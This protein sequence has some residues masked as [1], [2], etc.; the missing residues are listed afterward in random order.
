[1]LIYN[2]KKNQVLLLL[3]LL[4]LAI[5]TETIGN[6]I[7]VPSLFLE[8]EYRNKVDFWSYFIMGFSLGV[9]TMSYHIISY[10]LDIPKFSF[11]GLL[12]RPFTKF[13]INNSLLPF[14][15]ILTYIYKT[16]SYQ[17][18]QEIHTYQTIWE[19]T[20]GLVIG[21]L[22]S[23][24]LM[25]IYFISTNKD[26]FKLLASRVEKRLKKTRVIR[27]NVLGRIQDSRSSHIRVD[28]YLDQIFRL[29]KVNKD[30][31]FDRQAILK[32]FDQNHLNAVIIQLT[33]F[34]FVLLIGTMRDNI[35]FQI[36]AGASVLL[37]FT[38]ILM[39][40]G[41]LSYW[42]RGW[43]VT[44]FIFIL[45]T[46]NLLMKKQVITTN[47]EAYGLNYETAKADY[48]LRRVKTLS[49]DS[50]YAYD[51]SLT[52]LALENWKKKFQEEN[53]KQKPK[54]VFLCVSGGGQRAA[55]WAMRTLQIADSSLNGKLM[56]HTMLITGASGGIVGAAYFR[57]LCLRQQLYSQGEKI[58]YVNPY[59]EDL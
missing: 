51:K 3:W 12:R 9:F 53:P 18:S 19:R 42:L 52:L 35:I 54:M 43:T 30:A 5:V 14:L 26:I 56:K 44:F 10:I 11:I 36:P 8:P 21:L 40:A 50:I 39:F 4:I 23:S 38:I 17:Q 46:L 7:G 37:L 31:F 24:I 34:G 45:L 2:I 59:D 41:A 13:F 22:F 47:Y 55:V 29:R 25:F 58:P 28:Y 20:G 33:L 48:S 57:E 16:I 32:V 15:V 1:L 6:S 49:R 27:V